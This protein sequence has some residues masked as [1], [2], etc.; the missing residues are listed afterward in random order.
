[1]RTLLANGAVGDLV[2]EIQSALKN[3]GFDTQGIDGWY[4]KD[5]ANAVLAF[6]QAHSLLATG[7]IDEATWP[8]LMHVPVPAVSQRSLQL[9]AAFEGHG[10]EL[11]VGNFDGALLTWGIIGFTLASGEIQE[12][13]SAINDSEPQLID[14]AF[15]E[16]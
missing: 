6:Q 11:V 3:A 16:S 13:I 1:M 2:K 5:T 7:T 12:I 9:T 8:V 10:F 4:G 14:Q 15:G